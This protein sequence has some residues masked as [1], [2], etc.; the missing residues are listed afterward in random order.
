M[1]RVGRRAWRRRAD[2]LR[3]HHGPRATGHR[4]ERMWVWGL[5]IGGVQVRRGWSKRQDGQRSA[6]ARACES[7]PAL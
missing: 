5:L 4:R 2:A 1:P 6:W 7:C 3:R